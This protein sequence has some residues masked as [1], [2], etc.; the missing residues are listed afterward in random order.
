IGWVG[1][2]NFLCGLGIGLKRYLAVMN[3]N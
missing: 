3:N 2:V 1:M